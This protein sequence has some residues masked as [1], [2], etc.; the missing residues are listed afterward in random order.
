VKI[1]LANVSNSQL[2]GPFGFGNVFG[3]ATGDNGTLYGVAGTQIFTVDRTT[4]AGSSPIN[5]G[6]Q[7]LGVAFGETFFGEATPGGGT[8]GPPNGGGGGTGGTVPEP[9]TLLLLG[10]GLVGLMA[11]RKL[12]N[13]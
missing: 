1:D 11:A 12:K 13:T 7:G 9:A 5:F 2:V 6:G 10:T 3:L 4:G 8:G